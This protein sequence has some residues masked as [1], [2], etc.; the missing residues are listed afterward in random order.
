MEFSPVITVAQVRL[1]GSKNN[2]QETIAL[3]VLRLADGDAAVAETLLK[4]FKER[5]AKADGLRAD[6]ALRLEIRAMIFQD[7][8]DVC[9][10]KVRDE[11]NSAGAPY[12]P[13]T[14]ILAQAATEAAINALVRHKVAP[15]GE[16]PA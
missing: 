6:A 14:L 15:Y 10:D 16:K 11:V 9:R 4:G 13:G 1:F 3:A 2:C 8:L 12:W 7:I 5:R